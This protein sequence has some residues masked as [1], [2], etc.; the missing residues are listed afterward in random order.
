MKNI[1]GGAKIFT[2]FLFQTFF[3]AFGAVGW[4]L[5]CDF[6]IKLLKFVNLFCEPGE[7]EIPS[8]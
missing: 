7:T 8:P 5:T 6:F 3:K 4:K 2:S 1:Q